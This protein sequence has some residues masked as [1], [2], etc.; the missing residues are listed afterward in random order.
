M[1][2]DHLV[3]GGGYCVLGF[4]YIAYY[5]QMEHFKKSMENNTSNK[6]K[7]LFITQNAK[8]YPPNKYH[9][10][11]EFMKVRLPTHPPIG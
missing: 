10:L 7:Y 3:D 9:I 4:F 1:Y 11:N 6:Y 5:D 2:L 8:Q